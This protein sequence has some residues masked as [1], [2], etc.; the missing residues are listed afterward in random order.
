VVNDAVYRKFGDICVWYVMFYLVSSYFLCGMICFFNLVFILSVSVFT[1][2]ILYCLSLWWINVCI[3]LSTSFY[4]ILFIF[5]G[6]LTYLC[7]VS[8]STGNCKYEDDDVS[9]GDCYI[10][11]FYMNELL[12]SVVSV[13]VGFL[14]FQ[15][16]MNARIRLHAVFLT[17]NVS[18]FQDLLSVSVK[19]DLC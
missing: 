17:R 18:T 10:N 11:K 4:F 13:Y 7:I 1:F 16:L 15:I 8:V 2:Y 9:F 12:T 3:A 5:I 6:Q 14:V 19:M